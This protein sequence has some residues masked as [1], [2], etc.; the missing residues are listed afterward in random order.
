M[1]RKNTVVS[2]LIL[3]LAPFLTGQ[4]QENKLLKRFQYEVSVNVQ[5]IPMFAIDSQGNPVY[6]LKKE[7]I[8]LYADGKPT[9]IIYFAQYRLEE[10][11]EQSGGPAPSGQSLERLNFIIMDTL[12]SNKNTVVPAQT[13]AMGII[14]QAPPGDAFVI[15]E[16]NQI[17]GFRY[18]IGPEKD[19]NVLYDAIKGIVKLY[20]RRRV[21]LTEKLPKAQDYSDPKAYEIALQMFGVAYNETQREREKYQHDIWM[22]ADSLNQLKYALK[23][24]THPKTVYLISA[25]QIPEAMGDTAT[26][27]RFLEDAAKAINFGGSMFYLINP[28]KQKKSSGGTELKFMADQVGGKF[29]TGSSSGDIIRQVTQSTSAYY[30]AAYTTENQED[31]RSRIR[32]ECN[33]K[34]VDLIT[35]NYSERSTPYRQM[36]PMEKKLFALNV[37]NGGSWSRMVGRVG[38]IEFKT[39]TDTG[40]PSAKTI[41]ISTPP[42]MINRSLDLFLVNVDPASGKATI[43]LNTKEGREK[44]VLRFPVQKGQYQ[45]FVIIEPSQPFCIYNKVD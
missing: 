27:F 36:N 23:T 32:L 21:F 37:I 34:E 16:S 12:I 41:E 30:E 26:Y 15:L 39:L 6:D 19:K 29:I 45:Y 10:E 38:K 28:L 8:Q 9:D 1:I 25:G 3:L 7:E 20:M 18:V 2:I 13:V 31:T 44:E 24:I 14:K 11:K 42:K 43:G 17:S 40:D 5:L 22:F 33:R 35:I 4:D